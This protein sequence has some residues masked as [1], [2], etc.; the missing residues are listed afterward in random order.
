MQIVDT[1]IFK[2]QNYYIPL[3]VNDPSGSVTPSKRN[4]IR[5]FM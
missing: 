3:S 5:L 2:D 1:F 4:G